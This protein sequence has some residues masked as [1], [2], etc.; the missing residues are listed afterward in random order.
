M[1]GGL[2]TRRAMKAVRRGMTV[3]YEEERVAKWLKSRRVL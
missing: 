1:S 3:R 2:G